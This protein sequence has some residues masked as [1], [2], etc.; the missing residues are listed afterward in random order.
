MTVNSKS[1]CALSVGDSKLSVASSHSSSSS[2][3]S[4]SSSTR[5]NQNHQC[6]SNFSCISNHHSK[7][8]NKYALSDLSSHDSHHHGRSS[9]DRCRGGGIGGTSHHERRYH[10]SAVHRPTCLRVVLGCLIVV[11]LWRTAQ[12]IL[13][14]NRQVTKAFEASSQLATIAETTNALTERISAMMLDGSFFENSIVFWGEPETKHD[15]VK[16]QDAS[17]VSRSAMSAAT[18]GASKNK[19]KSPAKSIDDNAT[20]QT[21]EKSQGR[22]ETEGDEGRNKDNNLDDE[23]SADVGDDSTVE[24]KSS[25]DQPPR[26]EKLVDEQRASTEHLRRRR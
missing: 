15:D 2:S 7:T 13:E 17:G 26:S 22:I 6:R 4:S 5:G 25:T 11:S 14:A 21:A 18:A 24:G 23:V 3:C 1:A 10:E 12:C 8:T 19:A 16:K 9:A 20:E